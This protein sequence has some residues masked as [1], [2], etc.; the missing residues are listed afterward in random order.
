MKDDENK[1]V[2]RGKSTTINIYVSPEPSYCLQLEG[3]V[4]EAGGSSEKDKNLI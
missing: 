3:P 1:N 4:I 2:F